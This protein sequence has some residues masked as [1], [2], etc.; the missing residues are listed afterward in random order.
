MEMSLTDPR[1]IARAWE[2]GILSWKLDS[3]Q[4]GMYERI[5]EMRAL[6]RKIVLN[7][8]RQ[9][10]KSYFICVYMIEQAIRNPGWQIKYAA[11]TAKQVRKILKPH[12]REILKDCPEHLRPKWHSQDGEYRFPNGSVITVAG[13]DRDN[14][15]TLRGQ[16]CHLGI[17]DEGG[18]IDDLLYVVNDILLPQ[19]LNTGGRLVIISTPAKTPGHAFKQLCD[20]AEALGTLIERD[21]YCNPRLS[22]K[23]LEELKRDSGGEESTTWK[24]EYLCQHVTDEA[25]AVIPEATKE[26]VNKIVILISSKEDRSYRPRYFDTYVF[27][28]PGWNPD[29]AGLTWCI[30]DFERSAW[31][32]ER[33]FMMRKMA[34]IPLAKKLREV[35]DELWGKGHRPY[36]CISDIDHRLIAD[37]AQ[38]K[39]EDGGPWFFTPTA[40]DNLDEAI[41]GVRQSLTHQ[42]HPLWLHPDAKIAKRQLQNATWNKTRTKF[43]RTSLD[44]HYDVLASMIY[45]RRNIHF[46]HN[47]APATD[48]SL[49]R[50]THLVIQDKPPESKAA[51]AVK[52]MFGLKARR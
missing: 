15:E 30:T 3:N 20:E 25:S 48:W 44:G 22:E 42:K 49:L 35:T 39:P 5:A 11:Q 23:D 27:L 47:P 34:T 52:A 45:G 21:I 33:D 14:A 12:F 50:A 43:A 28:D 13:C 51:L 8:S 10:G 7:C 19:T 6:A 40:K 9:L 31:I 24:R 32:I 36:M 16:H 38:C 17:V 1:K 29:F 46:A 26:A 2:K 41:N 4:L 18:A 37:L